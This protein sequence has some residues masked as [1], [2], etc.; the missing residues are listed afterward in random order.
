MDFL[1]RFANSRIVINLTI[2]FKR[3]DK[4]SM[5]LNHCILK[6]Y[7]RIA[8]ECKMP[9]MMYQASIFRVFQRIFMSDDRAHKELVV[10]ARFI[11]RGFVETAIKNPKAYMELLFWKSTK[12]AVEMTDGYDTEHVT[13]KKAS[14]NAWTEVEEDELRTLFMEHQTTKPSEDLVDFIARNLINQDRTKRGIVKKM[15]ELGLVVNSK[16][17]RDE[18]RKRLPKEWSE[19]EVAQLTELWEQVKED[20][21]VADP[22]GIIYDGLRIK[23][24]KPKIKEKLLEL[25]L[26]D[27]VKQL[28]KKRV[29][30]SNGPKSSWEARSASE[31][32][33]E[34]GSH[35]ESDGD[36]ASGSG[37]ASSSRRE[38]KK[39]DKSKRPK[40]KTKQPE[41]VYTDAQLTGL[42]K[43]VIAKELRS[44]LE[45]L[46]ES[47]EDWLEDRD[48][49]S[50]ESQALV[51]LDAASSEAL[52]APSFQRLLRAF[53]IH[54]PDLEEA[55]WRIPASLLPTTVTRRCT[56]IAAA[57]RGEF[58]Q[59]AEPAKEDDKDDSESESD[60]EF[61]K[62]LKSYTRNYDKYS[63]SD[64]GDA[65][66]GPSVSQNPSHKSTS[67][68]AQ[69][70][71]V[72]DRN[73]V[74]S[75]SEKENQESGEKNSQNGNSQRSR[76]RDELSKHS[77][78][79]DSSMVSS[80]GARKKSQTSRTTKDS[81]S[82]DSEDGKTSQNRP[83][84][85]SD[86]DSSGEDLNKSKK[87]KNSDSD[88]DSDSDSSSNSE[89]TRTQNQRQSQTLT[90]SQPNEGSAKSRRIRKVLNSD[91]EEES[92]K[93]PP[94]PI[95]SSAESKRNISQDSDGDT[96]VQ[97]R[98]R[99]LD[100]DEEED[101]PPE[102]EKPTDRK[103]A[104]VLSDDDD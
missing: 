103:Q 21:E 50:G 68:S 104:R 19:D 8:V 32:E 44:A 63:S 77:D 25:N 41:I 35:S 91:S 97:K 36:A 43:D 57:L 92:E 93:L 51:P 24:P 74:S 72:S 58:V 28:R 56:L 22:L 18:V 17:V 94:S 90:E 23:R 69:K 20:D 96:P 81:D 83:N 27:D 67:K 78:A 15:K 45:W 7:H 75:G 29:K 53:G 79:D 85:T 10:F 64:E 59:E 52:D 16:G 12:Q 14:R 54:S 47:L 98:R 76:N 26:V 71:S 1:Q 70:S 11:F 89:E 101:A 95:Q 82:S 39:K 5:E 86:Q 73:S 102:S 66:P 38:K 65:D 6:M 31:D 13:N 99:V 33:D 80:Q 34:N 48:E 87:G 4:N 46:K 37:V 42:L 3:F 84:N 40:K 62:K 49:E 61:F 9:A 2:L 100:S 30:K 60:D 55:Y 88:S